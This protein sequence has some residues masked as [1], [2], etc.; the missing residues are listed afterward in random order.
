MIPLSFA[1]TMKEE[2]GV[3]KEAL[4]QSSPVFQTKFVSDMASTQITD[5]DSNTFR[6]VIDFLHTGSVDFN[7]EDASKKLQEL[8]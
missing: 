3:E 5:I 7:A 8:F 2:V 6:Q 1:R 4:S